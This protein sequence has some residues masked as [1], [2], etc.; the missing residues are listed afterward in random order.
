MLVIV[1]NGRGAEE[2]ARFIRASKQVVKPD[3]AVNVK[4]SGF[5]LSDGDLKSQKP[6][7]DL[8]KKC[9]TPLLAIGM[10]SAFLASAFGTKPVS[11]KAEK[12]IKVK[13]ERP[14]PLVLD[15]KKVF[16]AISNCQHGIDDLPENFDVFASSQRYDFE[17]VG[18]MEQ[19]F[20][21]VHFNPE[22][23]GDGL[24]ILDNFVKFVDIWE[25]YH[26]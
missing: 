19:P 9:N 16:T 3:E 7:I 15:M 13:I 10:G 8:V 23:G 17:I 5:I 2:I 11:V 12:N 4:A 18:H 26:K 1:D 21:G 14:S 22:M 24:K 25:K 20:F 6:N